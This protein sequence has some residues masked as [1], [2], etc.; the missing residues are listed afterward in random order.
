MAGNTLMQSR[1][2]REVAQPHPPFCSVAGAVSSALGCEQYCQKAAFMV[3]Y[4]PQ[5]VHWSLRDAHAI[6]PIVPQHLLP[7]SPFLQD[8]YT[9]YTPYISHNTY[10]IHVY[11]ILRKYTRFLYLFTYCTLA[12]WAYCMHPMVCQHQLEVS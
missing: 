7:S 10:Y 3:P 1:E 2:G 6:L 4:L 12:H 8:Y 11:L 9:A 5:Y